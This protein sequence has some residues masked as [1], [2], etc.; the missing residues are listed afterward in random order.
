MDDIP[1]KQRTWEQQFVESSYED[2]FTFKHGKVFYDDPFF[3]VVS[4]VFAERFG[5]PKSWI[6]PE[7]KGALAIAWRPP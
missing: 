5:M 2:E 4:S 7:L 1:W 6:D 3:W